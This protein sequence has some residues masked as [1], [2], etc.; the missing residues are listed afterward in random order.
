M[1]RM[2]ACRMLNRE[3]CEKAMEGIVFDGFKTAKGKFG[4]NTA[5]GVVYDLEEA[6]MAYKDIEDVISSELDLIKPLV[7]LRP[8]G[9]V[10]G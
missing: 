5:K 2:E 3:E 4:R 7:K 1:G 9:V 10:K 6:P 8:I